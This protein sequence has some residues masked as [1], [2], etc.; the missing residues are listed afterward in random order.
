MSTLLLRCCAGGLLLSAGLLASPLA[1]QRAPVSPPSLTVTPYAFK[2][3][4]GSTI[5]AEL[6]AFEVPERRANPASRRITLRFVRFR[7]TAAK[8]GAPIVYLAGGPGASGIRTA[9]GP[10]FPLFMALRALGDV[11]ALDQRGVGRR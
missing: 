1:S 3:P 10:R 11:I 2:A 5:D 7:S 4:D 9:A 6:G 8:P